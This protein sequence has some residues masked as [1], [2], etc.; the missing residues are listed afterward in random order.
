MEQTINVNLVKDDAIQVYYEENAHIDNNASLLFI[1]SGEAEI[2]KYVDTVSK[3]EITDYVET[4]AKPLVTQIA[5]D[6]AEPLVNEYIEET[7]KPAIDSYVESKEPELQAYV[8]QA[9]QARDESVSSASASA[10]SASASLVSANN[11]KTSE[12]NAKTSETNASNSASLAQGY[13]SD[14]QTSLDELKTTATDNFNTN[15]SQKTSAFDDNYE[16]KLSSFNTNA[17]SKTNDFNSNATQKT[18]QVNAIASSV[19]ALVVGFD[20]TVAT[21]TSEFNQNATNKTASF[22]SNATQQTND[23]NSNVLS[24][25][26]TFNSNA[27]AKTQAFNTNASEKQALVDA[28]ATSASNSASLAESWAIGDKSAR[29]E[30]S[31]KYWAEQSSAGQVQA[32]WNQTDSSQKDFIKNKPTNLSQFVNDTDYVNATQLSTKQDISD[33]SQTIDTSTTKYPSNK[34]VQDALSDTLQYK[35]ITNCITSIPQDIKLELTDGTLT[36]KAGSKIYDGAGNAISLN[37]DYIV[38]CSGNNIKFIFYSTKQDKAYCNQNVS[39][40]S[41]G[42]ISPVGTG[43]FYNTSTKSVDFYN[44]G[45]LQESNWSFP[46]AIVNVSNGVPISIEQT[47]NGFG[48]IGSTIFSLPGVEGLIPNGRDSD[49]TSNN[50]AYKTS[51]VITI[52]NGTT[53]TGRYTVLENAKDISLL[54]DGYTYNYELNINENNGVKSDSC[55]IGTVDVSA[56]KIISF[57]LRKTFKAVDEFDYINANNFTPTGKQTI[58][59][60]GMPDYSAGIALTGSLDVHYIAPSNGWVVASLVGNNSNARII[61]NENT[62]LPHTNS[63]QWIQFIYPVEK[64]DDIYFSGATGIENQMFYPCL[65]G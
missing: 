1:K 16:S 65:G 58:V 45:V 8:T 35:H 56:G 31:A 39:D 46:L 44:S 14:A 60:W 10:S 22:N 61:I 40:C 20:E 34:A 15:A 3:P 5:N 23:F 26:N 17:T 36:L 4:Q 32:D 11:A 57:N 52:T 19:S 48:Y 18:E 50:Y 33:L 29:P 12:T 55:I 42:A 30:G 37:K 59:A 62:N 9:E 41:S 53:E 24:K 2:Q 43:M 13:A 6:I 63:A 64:G 51:N 47:F 25:T 28:S 7:T 49:G 54:S 38:L 21:K 27:D